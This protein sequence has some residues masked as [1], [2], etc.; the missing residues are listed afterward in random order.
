MIG[1]GF[2]K[3]EMPISIGPSS[4]PGMSSAIRFSNPDNAS[5]SMNANNVRVRFDDPWPVIGSALIM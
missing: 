1:H 2:F 4:T 5:T 3:L